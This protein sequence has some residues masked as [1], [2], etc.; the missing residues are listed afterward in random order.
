MSLDTSEVLLS[1]ERVFLHNKHL[2]ITARVG[3]END[4]L[5]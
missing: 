3:L 1:V 4:T 2:F 5:S